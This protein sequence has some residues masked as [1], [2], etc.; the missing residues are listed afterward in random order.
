MSKITRHRT[1]VKDFWRVDVDGTTIGFIQAN[2]LHGGPI[3]S[4]LLMNTDLIGIKMAAAKTL[5]GCADE[6]AAEVSR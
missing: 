2:R 1:G 3:I 5:P 4:Y 6:L